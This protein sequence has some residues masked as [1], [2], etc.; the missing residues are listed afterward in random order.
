MLCC[1]VTGDG[2]PA[3]F[4]V[5]TLVLLEHNKHPEARGMSEFAK[6]HRV[7]GGGGGMQAL[8]KFF[9]DVVQQL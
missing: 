6:G 1:I 7:G 3:A 9:F 5:P 8:N 4:S 2:K